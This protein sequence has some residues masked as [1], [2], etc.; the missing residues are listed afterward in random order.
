MPNEIKHLDTFSG[1]KNI[2]GYVNGMKSLLTKID[3]ESVVSLRDALFEC[4][5][6][7]KTVYLAGNG[8]SESNATHLAND[9]IYGL[10]KSTFSKGLKAVSLSTNSSVCSA[11]S[12]DEGYEHIYSKQLNALANKG[13]IL[14]VF[15]GS[16]NSKNIINGLKTAK[17]LGLKTAGFLGFDGGK[18]KKL[19]D[20]C[21]HTETYNMQLSEDIQIILG[22]AISL[23]LIDI[24]KKNKS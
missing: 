13:D 23:D 5:Q 20:I 11:I 24:F 17:S 18:A 7:N 9:F 12:N 8:G 1:P 19:L 22:H 10:E 21:I 6:G 15:S 4:W 2:L 3:I 14:L 16:G